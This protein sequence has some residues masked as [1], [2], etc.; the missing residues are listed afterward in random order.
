MEWGVSGCVLVSGPEQLR[1]VSGS[2]VRPGWMDQCA[3]CSQVPAFSA[4]IC[5][6]PAWL[7]LLFYNT[8]R[9]FYFLKSEEQALMLV[10]NASV[11]HLLL[12]LTKIPKYVWAML[13]TWMITL[14]P[15]MQ[16]QSLLPKVTWVEYLL[17]EK[18]VSLSVF[19]H[20]RIPRWPVDGPWFTFYDA[21]CFPIGRS[22]SF[23][24]C[25]IRSS[26]ANGNIK[27]FR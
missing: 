25:L 21:F 16:H 17:T 11:V 12:S 20:G 3:N 26:F 2:G 18:C 6:L 9:L 24:E 15:R 7:W 27:F 8:S 4:Q 10:T 22:F 19:L 23:L 5:L 13:W 14:V 1:K